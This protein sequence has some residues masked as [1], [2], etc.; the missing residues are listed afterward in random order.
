[1]CT[2]VTDYTCRDRQKALQQRLVSLRADHSIWRDLSV[3]REGLEIETTS[4][5]RKKLLMNF[6]W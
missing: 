2:C 3:M 6:Q 4:M 5:A 1:M